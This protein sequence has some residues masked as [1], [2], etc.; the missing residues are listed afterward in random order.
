MTYLENPDQLAEFMIGFFNRTI[1]HSFAMKPRST[2][3][4]N[5]Q[6]KTSI[7]KPQVVNDEE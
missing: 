1:T 4:Q 2:V 7:K 3:K 6:R 5:F